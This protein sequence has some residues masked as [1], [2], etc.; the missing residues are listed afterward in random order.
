[1]E[2]QCPHKSQA[3]QCVSVISAGGGGKAEIGASK[4][5]LELIGQLPYPNQ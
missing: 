3:W 2:P 5:D 4:L 1:M